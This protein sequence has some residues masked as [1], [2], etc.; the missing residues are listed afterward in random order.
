[1]SPIL[2]KRTFYCKIT[3]CYSEVRYKLSRRDIFVIQG[4]PWAMIPLLV[5]VYCI[6]V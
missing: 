5:I 6:L 4:Q 2:R 1:M 3:C